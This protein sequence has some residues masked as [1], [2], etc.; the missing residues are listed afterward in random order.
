MNT[1][2]S[3][4]MIMVN[5]MWVA[6][7]AVALLLFVVVMWTLSGTEEPRAKIDANQSAQ[8]VNS[9]AGPTMGHETPPQAPSPPVFGS[10][11]PST[12]QEPPL[13][14]NSPAVVRIT[15][16][17]RIPLTSPKQ[18]ASATRGMFPMGNVLASSSYTPRHKPTPK[19]IFLSFNYEG[20]LWQFTGK[21]A[22][23]RQIDITPTGFELDRRKVFA[24]ANSAAPDK[25]LFVQSMHDPNKY[26]IYR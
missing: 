11:P 3:G 15:P 19:E 22:N 25:V 16:Q 9:G 17:P 2:R 21:F 8:S 1:I 12:T 10:M 24:F 18:S 26:A 4:D 5:W 23:I 14:G 20:R 13:A 7:G 6:I